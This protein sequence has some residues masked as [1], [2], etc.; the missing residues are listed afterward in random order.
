MSPKAFDP[1]DPA[2]TPQVLE[3][4]MKLDYITAR[5]ESAVSVLERVVQCDADE[6]AAGQ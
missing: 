3:L 5:L 4:L 6:E 1:T 2:L